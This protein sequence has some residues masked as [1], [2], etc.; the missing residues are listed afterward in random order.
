MS[1][2]G[3]TNIMSHIFYSHTS[4]L[5]ISSIYMKELMFSRG[6]NRHIVRPP[7]TQLLRGEATKTSLIMYFTSFLHKFTS[8]HSPTSWNSH[9]PPIYS[10]LK[11]CIL[12]LCWFPSVKEA[13]KSLQ[14]T[15]W[16]IS[17]PHNIEKTKNVSNAYL[18][19]DN[20]NNKDRKPLHAKF[21]K[22]WILA[23]NKRG[24]FIKKAKQ[25]KQKSFQGIR[26]RGWF[27]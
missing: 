24:F 20:D 8:Y 18:K 2:R 4:P 3:L 9:S 25:M 21:V 17:I 1:V 13:Q 19:L 12:N 7:S 11:L 26:N 10:S 27:Y 22:S 5:L 14:G 15:I 16:A 23:S 6:M